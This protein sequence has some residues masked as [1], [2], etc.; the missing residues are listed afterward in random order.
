MTGPSTRL[1][2][3]PS[4]T[5]GP[6]LSIGLRWPDGPYAVAPGFAGATWLRGRVLDGAG[7]VVRDA[8]VETWQ[9]DEHGRFDH[10]DDSPAAR[11]ADGFRGFGRSETVDGEF[12]VLTVKP[13]RVPDGDGGQQAPHVLISVF[14]R[15]LLNRLV[16]RLCFADEEEANGQ[17]V[18]LASV[19]PDR[20]PTLLARP[21]E[22]GYRFDVVLQGD[23]ET[24][25][26]D[27]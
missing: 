13:G 8:L 9:A 2:T 5:A 21:G 15:G 25:F 12:A 1:A 6:Y 7:E 16:T 11:R 22:D 23:A 4:Q 14:A 27:V 3:T 26:F 18:V 10:A 17:D 19:P 24:V 20:R